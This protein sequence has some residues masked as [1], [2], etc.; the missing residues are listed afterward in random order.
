[1]ITSAQKLAFQTEGM[2]Y[3]TWMIFKKKQPKVISMQYFDVT[4]LEDLPPLQEGYRYFDF[5]GGTKE[6]R[7]FRAPIDL[8]RG[9][10]MNQ[11]G[12]LLDECVQPIYKHNGITISQDTSCPLPGFYI[13]SPDKQ[14]RS[15]DEVD[16]ITHQRL[17]FLTR[18]I[19]KLMREHLNI[20][21]THIYYEEKAN[22]GCHVH[23][24]ILPINDIK[25]NP[26]LYKFDVKDYMDQFTFRDNKQTILDFNKKMKGKK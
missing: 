21:F 22:K 4:K 2:V 19:R 6:Y 23:Y 13:V 3:R 10:F 8:S 14:F 5:I 12:H 1:M 15:I 9:T 7:C 24:W 18:E 25:Q 26:R 11:H 20:Q 17:S 16:P